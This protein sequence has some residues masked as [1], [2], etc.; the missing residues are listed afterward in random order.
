MLTLLENGKFSKDQQLQIVARHKTSSASR[1]SAWHQR[2]HRLIHSPDKN[3]KD[4][5]RPLATYIER[6]ISA[7]Q[8]EIQKVL[9]IRQLG[10]EVSIKDFHKPATIISE[11]GTNAIGGGKRKREIRTTTHLKP[12]SS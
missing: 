8:V 1:K 12:T 10:Y 11:P 3:D 2:L 5:P 6:V 7:L 4:E 9:D